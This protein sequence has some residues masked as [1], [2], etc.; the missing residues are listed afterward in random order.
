MVVYDAVIA[1]LLSRNL[2]PEYVSV[3]NVE[4]PYYRAEGLEEDG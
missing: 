1:D 2:T 3:A 4:K